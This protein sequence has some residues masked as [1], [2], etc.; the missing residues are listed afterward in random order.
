MSEQSDQQ[1]QAKTDA[2][3]DIQQPVADIP[4][5][6]QPDVAVPFD[7]DTTEEPDA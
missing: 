5:P 2:E 7:Q 6:G 3:E 1:K 4:A